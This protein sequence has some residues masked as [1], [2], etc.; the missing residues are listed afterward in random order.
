MYDPDQLLA[1]SN[2]IPQAPAPS[3]TCAFVHKTDNLLH[4]LTP[5]I[6][7][8]WEVTWARRDESL[9][10][11]AEA[12]PS[13]HEREPER[14]S[15]RRSVSD[16]TPPHFHHRFAAHPYYLICSFPPSHP[17][18]MAEDRRKDH[19]HYRC[20]LADM[21]GCG[22]R[23]QNHERNSCLPNGTSFHVRPE[24]P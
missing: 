18:L 7:V 9:R 24:P 5:A 13:V 2:G 3:S 16:R 1:L 21:T 8:R 6:L 14:G 22:D 4:P 19:C 10:S 23:Y 20:L 11:R 17:R 15:D 12:A